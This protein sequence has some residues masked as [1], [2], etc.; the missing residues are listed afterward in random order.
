MII[1][2]LIRSFRPSVYIFFFFF[3][4]FFSPYRGQI[5]SCWPSS[6]MQMKSWTKWPLSWTVWTAGRTL[7]GVHCWSTSSAP[8]RLTSSLHLLYL[9]VQ[10]FVLFGHFYQQ[11]FDFH[12]GM[13]KNESVRICCLNIFERWPI[14]PLFTRCKISLWCPQS[15]YVKF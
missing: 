11:V 5:H 14:M 1:W 2:F 10:S 15:V 4:F 7:R 13:F 6:T 12:S 3:F 9:T 8:A